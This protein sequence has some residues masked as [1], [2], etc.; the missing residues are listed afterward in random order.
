MSSGDLPTVNNAI[1]NFP[2]KTRTLITPNKASIVI[3]SYTNRLFI[4][5]AEIEAGSAGTLVEFR[6]EFSP[7]V[8]PTFGDCD[9][10]DG[11][12]EQSQDVVYDIKVLFGVEKPEILLAAR[13]LGSK[14]HQSGTSDL[15]IIFGFGLKRF[16]KPLLEEVANSLIESISSLQLRK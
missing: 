1:A 5:V 16:D 15:P 12:G 11:D 10:G 3:H 13:V 6:K 8:P 9:R 14:L 4:L 2:V 7:E